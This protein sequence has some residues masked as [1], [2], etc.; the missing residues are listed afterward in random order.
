MIVDGATDNTVNGNGHKPSECTSASSTTGIASNDYGTAIAVQCCNNEGTSGNR[1]G[2][3]S[4]VSFLAAEQACADDGGRLCTQS[5][6][7]A[8]IG[9]G[10]GCNFDAYHVWTSTPC[11]SQSA[12]KKIRSRV[13]EA[14][15]ET[16]T[17]KDFEARKPQPYPEAPKSSNRD[18]TGGAND[19]D[20]ETIV[21]VNVSRSALELFVFAVTA[22]S[23]LLCVGWCFGGFYGRKSAYA[24]VAYV[25][26]TD[27]EENAA[28][29]DCD[30]QL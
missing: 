8:N 30:A 27:T 26:E 3:L 16:V 7:E 10:S 4:G 29:N 19:G 22:V 6:V 18:V 25:S 28:I 11:S 20:G 17:A 23:V 21:V 12:A 14:P 1:P 15:K 5:E 13:L 24:K 2:C 9:A